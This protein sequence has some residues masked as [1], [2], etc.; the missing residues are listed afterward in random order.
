MTTTGKVGLGILAV[1]L[2]GGGTAAGIRWSQRDLVTVQTST[3]IRQ[4]LNAVVTASGEIKPRNYINLGANAMGPITEL[5]VKEGDRVHKNQVVARIENTQAAA[6]VNAQKAAIASSEADSSAA[7]AGLKAQDDSIKTQQATLERFKNELQRSKEYLDRY[8]KLYDEKLVAKQDYDQKKADYESAGAS[9]RE[10]EARVQQLVS[11]RAQTLAQLTGAQKRVAQ[12][13]ANLA[14]L[15]NVLARFEVIAPLDGVVTNLPVRLGETVV[16]GVQNSAASTI[17]TIADM[18]LITAE[19]DVDETDIVNVAL[20]Q[21]ADVTIEAIP[22]KTFKGKVTQIG[23]SAILRSSGVA[24]SQSAT[25]TQ[26]AKDFKVVVAL[27]SP[28]EDI[29]P[30]LSATAKIV[31]ATRKDVTSIP[32]QALTVRTKGDLEEED[33]KIDPNAPLDPI[34]EKERREEI[35]GVFIVK[36]NRAQFVKVDTGIAGATDIEVLSGLDPGQQIVIGSYK[37]IRT[38]RNNTRIKIDNQLAIETDNKG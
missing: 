10:N 7:E 20:G 16:Q 1:A 23:N 17:L 19:V 36:D 3:V 24:A 21:V 38:M 35:Q 18:S 15:D 14:R 31:T 28:P 22:N 11:Q 27:D 32:I 25:S 29:R 12:A 33:K 8:Q 2:I 26:E 13:Q 37:A 34:K 30:G 6:D 4:D 5:L 9:V